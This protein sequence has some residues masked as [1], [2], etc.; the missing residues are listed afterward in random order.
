MLK[1]SHGED[2]WATFLI[3]FTES[4]LC[5]MEE[6]EKEMK[7]ELQNR[8]EIVCHGVLELKGV[9]SMSKRSG[10]LCRAQTWFP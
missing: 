8:E 2:K 4:H 1:A 7:L 9:G 6:F 10:G 5:P 3:S